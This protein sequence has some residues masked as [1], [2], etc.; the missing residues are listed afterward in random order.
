MWPG[1][2]FRTWISCR[3]GQFLSEALYLTALIKLN[4]ATAGIVPVFF[5]QG[6][7][8]LGFA[9]KRCPAFVQ[10]GPWLGST[11]ATVDATGAVAV[12][13]WFAEQVWWEAFSLRACSLPGERWKMKK[14]YRAG[15]DIWKYGA[16]ISGRRQ[17]VEKWTNEIRETETVRISGHWRELIKERKWQ[18]QSGGE[19][20]QHRGKQIMGRGCLREWENATDRKK[21]VRTSKK[22]KKRKRE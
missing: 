9:G 15:G 20:N 17:I 5:A 1:V 16:S 2:F 19:R 13:M 21:V 7:A 11:T 10:A 8:V 12:M 4:G 18:A 14:H 22:A 3:W 6:S